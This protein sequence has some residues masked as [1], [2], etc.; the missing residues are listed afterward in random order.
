M[1]LKSKLT[2]THSA[3]PAN[4]CTIWAQL[5]PTVLV[6]SCCR[7]YCES[8][9]IHFYT[10]SPQKS[11]KVNSWCS[12]AVSYILRLVCLKRALGVVV[13]AAVLSDSVRLHLEPGLGQRALPLQRR[14]ERVRLRHSGRRDGVL[15]AHH[16]ARRRRTLREHQRRPTPQVRRHRRHGLLWSAVILLLLINYHCR[17][18][19]AKPALRV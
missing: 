11:K 1:T 19:T 8:V 7:R 12:L 3:A 14:P 13:N 15:R 16:P 6:L 9:F 18:S 5:K 10:M 17:F 2:V 4:L